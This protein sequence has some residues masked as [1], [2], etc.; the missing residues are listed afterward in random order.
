[1]NATRSN[2]VMNLIGLFRRTRQDLTERAGLVFSWQL[3]TQLLGFVATTPLIGG[4]AEHLV[5]GSGSDVISN[6]D[7][8]RF[9]LSAPGLLFLLIVTSLVV[10]FYIAQFA[11][12]AWIAG[13]VIH[14]R[15]VDLRSTLGAV[16]IRLP[17][18]MRL[19][20]QMLLRMLLLALPFVGLIV[21]V[22][23]T[24]LQ[25]HDVNY[26][27]A[28]Q[29]PQWRRMLYISALLGAALVMVLI[30]QFGR[31]GF[32]I[33]LLMFHRLSP[34]AAL[35]TSERMLHGRLMR[36]LGPLSI[37]W[38]LIGATALLCFSVGHFFT[39]RALDWAGVEPQRVLPLVGLF[40][41]VTLASSFVFA[42]LLFG[43]HQSLTMRL[44][45]EQLGAP[46]PLDAPVDAEAE[47][48]GTRL[49]RPVLVATLGLALLCAGVIVFL[50]QHL[51]QPEAVAVTAHRGASLKAPENSIA[52]FREAWASG[53]DF[54]ELD[55]QRTRDGVI[56]VLHD[57][58]L[59]RVAGDPRK[60]KDL[61][62]A[63]IKALDIGSRLGPKY[64]G[65]RVPT[66]DEVVDLARGRFKLNI[67]LKYNVSDENLVPAVIDLLHARNFLDQAVITSLDYPALRQVEE[68][69][70]GLDTGLIVTA[71]LG[72]IM[73][74]RVDFLSVNQALVTASL[75]DM[76]R[77]AG[78]KIHAWTANTP[79]AMLRMIEYDVDN[80]I[81]DD[82]AGL[83]R[84]IR[85]RNGL[86]AR[87]QT[88]LRL[89][90]LFTDSPPELGRQ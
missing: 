33:P 26:Y 75:V 63:E 64:A 31:W 65:E 68:I 12:Y 22:A 90:V 49:V 42:T 11:G 7:I 67:E 82:P 84:V 69:E 50:V 13:H 21:L 77:V 54:V 57:A 40:M 51:D 62:L 86:S 79:A 6:Y 25:G 89:R 58:D 38:G 5:S 4:L 28:E 9:L 3:L 61:T 46:L 88:G 10:T 15:R 32:A 78:K 55:V 23:L 16:A 14:G 48:T 17:A 47:S 43:G 53:A 37:W 76:A 39:D 72:N 81:T 56:V 19:A 8:A 87:E 44:C 35:E 52:A 85:L 70:P 20:W 30:L 24:T 73:N 27:L 59:L 71:A 60:V 83:A 2:R 1:M 29:P 45:F 18:L 74:A 80:I 34:T 41:T 36:L 66:L